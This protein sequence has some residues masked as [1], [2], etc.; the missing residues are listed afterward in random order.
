MSPGRAR[1]VDTRLVCQNGYDL[2]ERDDRLSQQS[3]RS[4]VLV[5]LFLYPQCER[6]VEVDTRKVFDIERRADLLDPI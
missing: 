1:D 5:A 4:V 6:A 3:V 2:R